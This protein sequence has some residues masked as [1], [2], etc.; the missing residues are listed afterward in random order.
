MSAQHAG[1]FIH[2]SACVEPGAVIGAGSKIWHF[3]HVMAGAQ[4]GERVMLGQGCFVSS[5][6]RVGNGARIQN[7]VSLFDGVELEQDVFVGPCAVF[8]NVLNPRAHVSRRNEFRSTRVGRGATIGANATLL[9]G[10]SVGAYAF[11]AAG[12]VVTRDVP[13]HALVAGVPA[14]GNGWVSRHGERLTF[15][16]GEAR[17][18]MTGELY[19]LSDGVVSLALLA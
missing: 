10:I 16:D 4:L 6:A 8:T 17:C 5:G 12:A 1:V 14:R 2:A 9:P 3:C 13:D 7:N 11:V 19:L 18:P 15:S